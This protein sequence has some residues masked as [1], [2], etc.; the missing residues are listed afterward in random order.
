MKDYEKLNEQYG[1]Y[2]YENWLGPYD[3]NWYIETVL[4]KVFPTKE[5]ALD[6]CDEI[7]LKVDRKPKPVNAAQTLRKLCDLLGDMGFHLE[8]DTTVPDADW[9]GYRLVDPEGEEHEIDAYTFF[10]MGACGL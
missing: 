7:K 9:T 4:H 1:E 5:S 6:Y 2:L 8:Q 10:D 3:E